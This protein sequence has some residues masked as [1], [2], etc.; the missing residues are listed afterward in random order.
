[1]FSEC[2]QI[3]HIK[4]MTDPDGKSRGFAFVEYGDPNHALGAIRNLNGLELNGRTLRVNY[5]N[6]SHLEGLASKLGLDMSRDKLNE[7]TN[8]MKDAAHGGK[9]RHG[10]DDHYNDG[11]VDRVAQAVLS[12]TKQVRERSSQRNVTLKSTLSPTHT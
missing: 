12:L 7:K 4:M 6:N 8:Q 10:G 9:K 3:Q 5:S 11:G 1:M 2:G